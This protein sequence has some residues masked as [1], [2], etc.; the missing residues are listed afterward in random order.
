MPS[1]T[2]VVN[3]GRAIITN[4]ITGS[5]TEPKYIGVGTGATAGS[6]TVA[7][8]DT[9]LTTEVD[10]RVTGTSSRTTTSTTNDTYQVT[11]TFTC[12]ATS[13]TIT[14]VGLFDSATVAG[15][16]MFVRGVL[17]T[18]ATLTNGD[19]VALTFTVQVTSSVV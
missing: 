12:G 8:T 3:T 4:R 9:A 13:R 7:L 16:V 15:S 14:E 10:S 2:A 19:S 11:G 1:S 6:T 5:G 18:A 17:N